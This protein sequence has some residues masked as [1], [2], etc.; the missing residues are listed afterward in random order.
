[1]GNNP[2]LTSQ[3]CMV[4]LGLKPNFKLI[5]RLVSYFGELCLTINKVYER[6]NKGQGNKGT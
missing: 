2:H 3:I 6:R 1:M 4:E 5:E